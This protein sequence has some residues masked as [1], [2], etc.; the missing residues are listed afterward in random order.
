MYI[1][2]ERRRPLAIPQ[3]YSGNLFSES[4]QEPVQEAAAEPEAAPVVACQK[5]DIFSNLFD[6]EELLL[7]GLLILLSQDGFGDDIIP[8]LLIILFFKK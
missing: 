8:I 5:K 3:N 2:P 7:L 6:N 1:T 4:E